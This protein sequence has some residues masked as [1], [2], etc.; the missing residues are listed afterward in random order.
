V[1]LTSL[2]AWQLFGTLQ[3]WPDL[4]ITIHQG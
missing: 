3:V 1:T 4:R 2:T